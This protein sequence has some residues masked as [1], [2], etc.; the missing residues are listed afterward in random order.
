M[1]PAN[2]LQQSRVANCQHGSHVDLGLEGAVKHFSLWSA[3]GISLE[4]KQ[5][6]ADLSLLP[7]SAALLWLPRP[8]SQ[9]HM[10][11]LGRLMAKPDA[12]PAGTYEV[13][14]FFGKLFF[15]FPRQGFSV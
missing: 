2:W 11:T 6:P 12:G 15:F 4:A 14:D 9:L 7:R 5:G 8:S 10:P 1:S 13:P 3:T